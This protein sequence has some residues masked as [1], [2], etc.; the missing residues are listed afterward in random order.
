MK[1]VGLSD[2]VLNDIYRKIAH[3]MCN[4]NKIYRNASGHHSTSQTK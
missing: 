2:I 1:Y 4:V 3:A